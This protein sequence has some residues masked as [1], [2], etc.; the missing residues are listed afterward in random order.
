MSIN[1]YLMYVI[2][3][4]FKSLFLGWEYTHTYVC[5]KSVFLLVVSAYFR[6]LG[7]ACFAAGFDAVVSR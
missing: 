5:F 6:L 3:I 4:C 7:F 2:Y 1:K